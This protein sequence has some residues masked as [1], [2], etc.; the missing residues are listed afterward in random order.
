M[1]QASTTGPVFA[2]ASIYLKPVRSVQANHAL[3]YVS[4]DKPCSCGIRVLLVTPAKVIVRLD[5]R[6][7]GMLLQF[8]T[9][10]PLGIKVV[11]DTD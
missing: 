6:F 4:A 5:M 7:V 2:S 11:N 1:T 9:P 8:T 3:H 10:S